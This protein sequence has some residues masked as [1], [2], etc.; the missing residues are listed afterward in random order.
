MHKP[1]ENI[2]LKLALNILNLHIKLNNEDLPLPCGNT[3]KLGEVIVFS[4]VQFS[5]KIIR[6]TMKQENMAQSKEK[7]KSPET[8]PKDTRA[9]ELF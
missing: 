4:D 1:R 2:C 3:Q 7:N 8:Y 9:S 6:H 5:K